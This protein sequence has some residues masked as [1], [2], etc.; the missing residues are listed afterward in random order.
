VG[1]LFAIALLAITQHYKTKKIVSALPSTKVTVR[2]D[3]EYFESTTD[4]TQGR[5]HWRAFR[6]VHVTPEVILLFPK[7]G[8][9]VFVPIPTQAMSGEM[10]AFLIKKIEANGGKVVLES[11]K[12][13]Y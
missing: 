3:E 2:M 5:F 10:Q 4:D 1:M 11:Y 6:E 9:S 8:I 7:R 13:K 12:K